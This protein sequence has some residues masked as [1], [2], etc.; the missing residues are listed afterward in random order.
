MDH[1]FLM[2]KKENKQQVSK[3]SNFLFRF[4]LLSGTNKLERLALAG[5][6]G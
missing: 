6:L 4:L 3:L 1:T 5:I 2:S